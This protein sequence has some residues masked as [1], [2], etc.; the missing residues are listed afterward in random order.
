MQ[1]YKVLWLPQSWPKGSGIGFGCGG[2][3]CG[4]GCGTGL[5]FV[6]VVVIGFGGAVVPVVPVVVR[7]G[8][9]VV[10]VLV[11]LVDTVVVGLAKVLLARRTATAR[12]LMN[13]ILVRL[14]VFNRETRMN[15]T[16]VS[17]LG[18]ER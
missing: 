8:G 14:I 16:I 15:L 9:L 11:R 13:C 2:S 1:Q 3:G 4:N 7:F 10:V 12:M 5:R 17:I 18:C 6:V